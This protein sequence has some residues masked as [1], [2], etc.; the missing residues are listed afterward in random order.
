MSPENTSPSTDLVRWSFAINPAKR[1]AIEDHLADLGADVVIR[2]G[3]DFIVTWD[4]PEGD[5][6]DVIEALWALNGEPFE[7]I[8]ESFH[9]FALHTIDQIDDESNQQ[10]A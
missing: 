3:Q 4:E 7:V 1:G 2:D 8:E 9:R 10:A 6:S 5:L